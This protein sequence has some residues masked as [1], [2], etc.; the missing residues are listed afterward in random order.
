MYTLFQLYSW[1]RLNISI[2]KTRVST[3]NY[4]RLENCVLGT[5][6]FLKHR[7]VRWPNLIQLK[8]PICQC[9]FGSLASRPLSSSK[10]LSPLQKSEESYHS[11]LG[12]I[13]VLII[14]NFSALHFLDQS[15]WDRWSKLWMAVTVA[16]KS[17]KEC[18]LLSWESTFTASPLCTIYLSRKSSNCTLF[19]VVMMMM[20]IMMMLMMLHCG[21]IGPLLDTRPLKA[22]LYYGSATAS[23]LP[24]TANILIPTPPQIAKSETQIFHTFLTPASNNNLRCGPGKLLTSCLWKRHK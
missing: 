1:I 11:F 15:D 18:K 3:F 23:N 5:P 10:E 21:K 9:P 20:L 19:F 6:I 22:I 12:R 16:T 24:K 8:S 2:R 4:K 17:T 14:I 13:V 7:L